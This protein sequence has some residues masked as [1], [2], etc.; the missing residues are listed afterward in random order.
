MWNFV[1]AFSRKNGKML[2]VRQN[3]KWP[4][5]VCR[6][7]WSIDLT[8]GQGVVALGLQVSCGGFGGGL[9]FVGLAGDLERENVNAA[10][11]PPAV[12]AAACLPGGFLHQGGTPAGQGNGG[13]I[14]ITGASVGD[15]GS[16]GQ[17]SGPGGPEGIPQGGVFAGEGGD[18]VIRAVCPAK[19]GKV[20]KGGCFGF[21]TQDRI[22]R[23]TVGGQQSR[24]KNGRGKALRRTAARGGPGGCRTPAGCGWGRSWE[25]LLSV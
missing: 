24:F 25:W 22:L 10:E 1:K 15:P 23:L 16:C 8:V 17:S 12:T 21:G 14:Q 19:M 20:G 3:S 7:G 11:C 9:P 2:R 4:G 13:R 18:L 6:P 5:G